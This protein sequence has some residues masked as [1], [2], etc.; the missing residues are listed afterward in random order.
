MQRLG[1]VAVRQRVRGE[2]VVVVRVRGGGPHEVVAADHLTHGVEVAALLQVEHLSADEHRHGGEPGEGQ[3]AQDRVGLDLD[4]V[5]HVQ[6][7]GRVGEATGL[8]H[9]AAVPAGSAEVG[10]VEDPQPVAQ[11]LG[12][13]GEAR[14]VPHLAVSLVGH[15]H[16]IDHGVD[17][18]VGGQDLQRGHCVTRPVEGGDADRDTSV[19]GHLHRRVGPA[20]WSGVGPGLRRDDGRVPAT[21][22]QLD[23]CVRGEVEPDP[24]AVLERTEVADELDRGHAVGVAGAAHD[25]AGD[26]DTRAVDLGAVEIHPP[27]AA[28]GQAQ[29][30]GV[31]HGPPAPVR[32]GERVEVGGERDLAVRA[33]AQRGAAGRMRAPRVGGRLLQV[34]RPHVQRLAG[35]RQDDALQA[36]QAT[37]VRKCCDRPLDLAACLVVASVFHVR[38]S[39]SRRP[40]P[41][42]STLHYPRPRFCGA[43]AG[44]IV[45]GWHDPPPSP[46]AEGHRWARRA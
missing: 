44:S 32:G 10:L 29:D 38:A 34:Q 36:F 18:R 24:A 33:D 9:D 3:R 42:S 37:R 4:V 25:V 14:L 5:V 16:R 31:Q 22:Q 17:L 39:P 41:P 1:V 23:V 45:P 28:D 46:R 11:R 8:V 2:V 7:V 43:K 12:G 27:R 26:R 21:G 40:G 30:D 35:P 6:D 20:V 19:V 15:E 13:L